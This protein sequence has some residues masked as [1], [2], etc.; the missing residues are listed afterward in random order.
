M[1]ARL[2]MLSSVSQRKIKEPKKSKACYS[3]HFQKLILRK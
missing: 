3:V 2:S 1:K